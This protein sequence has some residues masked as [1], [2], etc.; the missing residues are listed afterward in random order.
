M[1]ALPSVSASEA[2][3]EKVC[4]APTAI[5]FVPTA[6]AVKLG[7]WFTANGLPVGSVKFPCEDAEQADAALLSQTK[8]YHGVLSASLAEVL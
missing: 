8:A 4:D 7:A 2:V 5:G 6:V 3:A 1:S